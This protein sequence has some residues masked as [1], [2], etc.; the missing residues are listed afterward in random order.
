MREL[1]IEWRH[2]AKEGATCDRCSAT[3]TSARDVVAVLT[4]ELAIQGIRVE[5]IETVL[6]EK[7]MAQSNMLLFNGVPLEQILEN[8]TASENECK[9]CSCL[10]G[11]DTACRTIEHEGVTHEEIPSELIRRAALLTVGLASE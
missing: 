2:Y 4:Q 10:T 7:L 5:F 8:A 1:R 9:S 6:P 3:G 11:T